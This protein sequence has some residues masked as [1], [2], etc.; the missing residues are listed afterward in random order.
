MDF[1]WKA[2]VSFR[3]VAISNCMESSS[4]SASFTAAAA[5][6]S[7]F[8][9]VLLSSSPLSSL[10]YSCSL[11]LFEIEHFSTHS[12]ECSRARE[13]KAMYSPSPRSQSNYKFCAFSL[14]LSERRGKFMYTCAL[15]ISPVVFNC[16]EHETLSTISVPNNSAS[17]SSPGCKSN[18]IFLSFA[19]EIDSA[20]S[21]EKISRSIENDARKMRTTISCLE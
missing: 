2:F 21:H 8:L 19:H 12:A 5:L 16:K 6:D 11:F 13:C 1:N 17:S 9:R 3:P 7:V 14:S 15:C 10:F 18:R 20:I 4:L